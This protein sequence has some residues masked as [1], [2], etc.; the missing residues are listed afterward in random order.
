MLGG[1]GACKKAKKEIREDQRAIDDG[2]LQA[3]K[4]L[5]DGATN[6][7][8]IS[9]DA[10][11]KIFGAVADN[12]QTNN[13]IR[14]AENIAEIGERGENA[15]ATAQL[16]ATLSAPDRVLFKQAMVKYGNDAF[17]AW[18]AV[19]QAQG[20]KF[21]LRN[22]YADYLKAFAGKDNLTPPMSIEAY[23][24]KMGALLPR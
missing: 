18:T 22:S 20:D 11:T 8:K 6:D 16:N 4:L 24:G 10:Q 12:F 13:R 5:A 14:S 23:A 3:K 2:I 7:L 1:G 21:N 9:A 17:K 15:R 19:Q